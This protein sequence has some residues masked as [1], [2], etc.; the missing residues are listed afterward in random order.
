MMHYREDL[1]EF[2]RRLLLRFEGGPSGGP[3]GAV[4]GVSNATDSFTGWV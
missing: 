4:L 2:E 1:A 3:S